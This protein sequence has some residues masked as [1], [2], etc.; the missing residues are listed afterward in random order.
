MPY[1]THNG[2]SLFQ[3]CWIVAVFYDKQ[4]QVTSIHCYRETNSL[5]QLFSIC[6]TMK[7]NPVEI[8]QSCQSRM[9][10]DIFDQTNGL[11]WL[12]SFLVLFI[13]CNWNSHGWLS[14]YVFVNLPFHLTP[15]PCDIRQ[16]SYSS[17]CW[18]ACVTVNRRC[19]IWILMVLS[20][21]DICIEHIEYQLSFLI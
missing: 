6:L 1:S 10:R 7:S 18:N 8:L 11:A 12:M 5:P 16:T 21:V 2:L 9:N 20:T 19:A 17:V 15:S 4:L 14:W 13:V 3:S